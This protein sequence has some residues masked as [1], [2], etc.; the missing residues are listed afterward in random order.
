MEK[1][2]ADRLIFSGE[3]ERRYLVSGGPG[4]RPMWNLANELARIWG[5][6]LTGDGIIILPLLINGRWNR[7]I[8]HAEASPWPRS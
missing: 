6:R 5:G 1:C 3:Q 7:F 2:T 4:N 8:D